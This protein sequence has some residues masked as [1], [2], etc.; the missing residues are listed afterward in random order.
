MS[1]ESDLLYRTLA[2]GIPKVGLFLIGVVP[3]FMAYVAEDR[4]RNPSVPTLK[5]VMA[6][7]DVLVL[8]N[9]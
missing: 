5:C 4:L 3:L 8:E 1:P 7:M 9:L 6:E 2:V